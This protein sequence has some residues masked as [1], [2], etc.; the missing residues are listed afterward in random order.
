MGVQADPE[1]FTAYLEEYGNTICGRHPI[2]ILLNVSSPPVS[3]AAV[4]AALRTLLAAGVHVIQA[5]IWHM[6][7]CWDSPLSA[8]I[9]CVQMSVSGLCMQMIQHSRLQHTVS[10]KKYDQSTKCQ[11][12]RES[13]VSYAAAIVTIA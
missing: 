4:V 6:A 8:L 12:V 9:A 1:G 3:H 5:A 7:S 10:F 2:G 13:S 11:S